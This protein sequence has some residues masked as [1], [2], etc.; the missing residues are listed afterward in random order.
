MLYFLGYDIDDELPWHSTVL[1]TRQL[2][3]EDLF[4]QLFKD[5]LKQCIDIGMV[6]GRR[7]AI[8]L[9][10]VQSNASMDSLK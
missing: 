10:P 7:Q 4:K 2:Y 6:A 8:D 9:A 3:G 5:V 1:R